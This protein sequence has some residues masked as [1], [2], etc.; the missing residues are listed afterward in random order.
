MRQLNNY[1]KI[2]EARNLL[3]EIDFDVLN[4]KE[5]RIVA[6]CIKLLNKIRYE[7]MTNG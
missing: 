2:D 3:A 7:D 1:N 6:K 5:K 4:R